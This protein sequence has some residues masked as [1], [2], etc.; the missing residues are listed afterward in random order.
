MLLPFDLRA[1][2]VG[3]TVL[4]VRTDCAAVLEGLTLS[5]LRLEDAESLVRSLNRL[6]RQVEG[7]AQRRVAEGLG[8]SLPSRHLQL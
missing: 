6:E 8:V 4:D 2:A 3:W 7:A 5:G 1:D